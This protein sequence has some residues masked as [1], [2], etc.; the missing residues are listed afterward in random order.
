M[1]ICYAVASPLAYGLQGTHGLAV[2]AVAG[3]IC[4]FSALGASSVAGFA[5]ANSLPYVPAMIAML[6][7]MFLPLV[8]IVVVAAGNGPALAREIAAYLVPFYL[9]ALGLETWFALSRVRA[10]YG[11]L[12]T[13]SDGP[14]AVSSVSPTATRGL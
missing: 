5:A 6:I 9:V 14:Q 3:V 10:A 2:A 1:A 4:L 7:R 13:K 11:Q 8:F 12:P